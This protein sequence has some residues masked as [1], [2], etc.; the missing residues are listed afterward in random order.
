LPTRDENSRLIQRP[1][2]ALD[3]HYLISFYGSEENLL[4]QQLLGVTAAELHRQAMLTRDTIRDSIGR[5][6]SEN[7][8]R[9][10]Y[11]QNSDL[12]RQIDLVR[13][14]PLSLNL[15]ELSKLWSV[16]FQTSYA[17]SMAYQASVILIESPA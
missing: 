8:A 7:A 14:A 13:L 11:L 4:P 2:A 6:I 5:L 16:F 1:A 17:L 10:G 12:V 15:E 3:L 9:Y